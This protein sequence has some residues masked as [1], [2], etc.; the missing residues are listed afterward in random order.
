MTDTTLIAL[1]SHTV[2]SANTIIYTKR[3]H[4]YRNAVVFVKQICS[5]FTVHSHYLPDAILHKGIPLR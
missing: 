5:F 4:I 3:C 2:V 1:Q